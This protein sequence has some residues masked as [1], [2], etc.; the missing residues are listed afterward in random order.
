[1]LERELLDDDYDDTLNNS[2]D[3]ITAARV[4][5]EQQYLSTGYGWMPSLIERE[6]MARERVAASAI[7]P[8]DL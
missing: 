7:L 5:I 1:M 4:E 6:A 2:S 8:L 3:P